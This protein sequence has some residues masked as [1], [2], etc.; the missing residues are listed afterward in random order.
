MID[1]ELPGSAK[2]AKAM[3]EGVAKQLFRP[4]ARKYDENEHQYPKELEIMKGAQVAARKPEKGDTGQNE[5]E[6]TL[7]MNMM[8][9]IATE[10]M[11]AGQQ[12]PGYFRGNRPDPAP[13][14]GPERAQAFQQG[15]EIIRGITVF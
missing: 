11:D 10:E 1:L 5:K 4:I 6:E 8:T 14:R 15:T 13:D 9:I 7:G 2:Q 3:L 12:D